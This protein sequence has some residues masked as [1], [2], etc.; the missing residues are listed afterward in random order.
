MPIEIERK[1]LVSNDAWRTHVKSSIE[2][3]QGYLSKDIDRTVRVRTW[4][5]LGKITVK[6]RSVQGARA[7]FEYDIPHAHAVEMLDTLCLPGS[8][9]KSRHLIPMGEYTWEIDEFLDHNLGLFLA[10]IELPDI[11]AQIDLPDWIGAEVTNDHRYQNSHLAK[12]QVLHTDN[13]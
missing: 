12:H 5:N 9:H 2:I 6:G 11:Q 7:E 4:G 10:E 8:V 1:F 13:V 3:R